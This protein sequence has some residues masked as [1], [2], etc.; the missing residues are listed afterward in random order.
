MV[1]PEIAVV[2]N[3]AAGGGKALKALARVHGV[4]KRLERPYAI[5][6]TKE[7]G[8]AIEAACRFADDGAE[9]IV[10]VGGDGTVN[11]VANG[12]HRSQA[13]P[14]LGIVPIGHGRDFARTVG[15]E[16]NVELAVLKAVDTTPR[17]ID[18]GL[19]TYADGTSRAFINIAGLGFDAIVAQ[20]AQTSRLPGA[21]LPY[22]ACAL[23]TLIGFDNIDIRIEAGEET[24]ET[25]AVFVQIANARYMGGGFLFAPMAKIDDGLLDVCVVGD[26]SKLELVRQIPKVYGGKHTGLAKFRHLLATSVH[27]SSSSTARLQLDGELLGETP[28]T[29]TVIPGGIRLAG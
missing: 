20:K 28:V 10:A 2:L 23:S 4:L 6:V 24:I 9:R 26:F 12:I 25:K 21:N 17:P 1:S 11:E 16:K 22:L 13:S 18:L 7:P 29:F 15:T 5:H 19:V 3:P 8:D 27:I 14:A